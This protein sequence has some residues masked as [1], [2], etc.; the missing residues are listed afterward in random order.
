MKTKSYRKSSFWLIAFTLCY[1][2][3]LVVITAINRFGA[4][5]WWPGALNLYLPQAMWLLPGVLLTLISL[6]VARHWAWIPGL[7]VIWVLG[8]IMGLCWSL[9]ASSE[10]LGTVPVRVMTCNAKYGL[11]NI[12]ALID[13]INLYKPDVI[14]LQDATGSL[15]GP[16]GELLRKWHVRSFGQY[17]TASRLP[18]DKAEV[19]PIDF[20]LEKRKCLRC[21][22]HIGTTVVTLY[23]VHLQT[24]RDGLNAFRTARHHP[25]YL[26]KAIIQLDNNVEDRLTQATAIKE[27]VRQEQG[28]VIV[29][30]DL[31]SSDSSLVCA[32]LR[33]A[34]LHDAFAEGGRG[35][36]YSYGHFL[37][38]H[39]LPWFRV[40]WMRIDHI[41]MSSQSQ[42][43][44]CWTGTAKASEHRPVIADLVL[45]TE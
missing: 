23:N 26:P 20:F 18:L 42:C 30:G 44:L 35:Y 7:C 9:Q 15:S 28:P 41:M 1:G 10:P 6:R 33:D 37:L 34:G 31:N 13:D 4:D 38:Q 45:K 11:H 40:S 2:S 39:R 12:D 29:A 36:G 16:L 24:P 19:I 17:V 14:L 8:P 43:R 3:I 25:W 32:T 5:S 21:R 27:F 22:M